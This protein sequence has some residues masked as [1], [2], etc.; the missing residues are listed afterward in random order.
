[1]ANEHALRLKTLFIA[2]QGVQ[3]YRATIPAWVKPDD[4]VLEIG[5][6]WGTTTA[7]IAPH[8][9]EVIG[10]DISSVCIE[11][12]RQR[13]PELCFAVLDAFDVSAAITLDRSFSVIYIDMSG[14]SGYRALLD[15]IALLTMYATVFRPRAI[16]VKS[17]GLKHFAAHCRI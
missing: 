11:R 3:E 8:C 6:E 2:T 15:V 12:A 13:H 17:G 14:L 16:V 4:V 1:M 10:T 9:R 7:L 5:C